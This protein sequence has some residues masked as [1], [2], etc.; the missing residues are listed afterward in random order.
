M[1]YY[2]IDATLNWKAVKGADVYLVCLEVNGAQDSCN[3]GIYDT[4]YTYSVN[5]ILAGTRLS[6]Y[7]IA[8]DTLTGPTEV[9]TR[10]QSSPELVVGA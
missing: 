5:G 6:Y 2:L 9:C 8:C 4:A 7:V 10:S 1:N 3:T